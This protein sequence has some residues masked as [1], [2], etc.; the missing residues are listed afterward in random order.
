MR[1]SPLSPVVGCAR[2]VSCQACLCLF[3]A[4]FALLLCLLCRMSIGLT[5]RAIRT[6]QSSSETR[7]EVTDRVFLSSEHSCT[8][9]RCTHSQYSCRA[10]TVTCRPP[11]PRLSWS[12]RECVSLQSPPRVRVPPRYGHRSALI[13]ATLPTEVY[14]TQPSGTIMHDLSR[15]CTI[16]Y[17]L[18]RIF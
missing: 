3:V 18:S 15:Y 14:H 1:I 4:Q 13:R 5:G 12:C 16:S 2:A 17:D 6:I 9:C 8:T 11:C 10:A 7:L